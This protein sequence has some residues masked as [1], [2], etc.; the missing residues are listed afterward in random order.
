[1]KRLLGLT[2]FSLLIV[3]SAVAQGSFPILGLS[4]AAPERENAKDFEKFIR[5][6]LA[7]L[8][9]NTLV[10]RVDYNYA[11]ETH[12]ELRNENPLTKQDVKSLVSTCKELNIKII[13]QINLL[14]HQ[15]W[16]LKA[17]KLLEVYP[18]F[19]ETPWVIFPEKYE[20]PNAD[21]LYCKSYC[22]L[23]PDVHK[24]VFDIV[25]ELIDAFE[26]DAFHAGMDEVF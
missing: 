2:I 24:V 9:V 10:L 4:I 5:E 8:G 3:S 25:G 6:E 1:M 19:D 17:E 23:H 20:W 16:E 15:S 14:G 12:P 13:P 22:P 21:G 11:Y 18:Q 26:T 7:P